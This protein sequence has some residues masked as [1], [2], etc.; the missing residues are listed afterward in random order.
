MGEIIWGVLKAYPGEWV[1]VDREGAVLAADPNLAALR[2][3]VP[4]A[5][6]YVYACGEDVRS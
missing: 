1:A 3:R 2:L 5:R 4:K 6:T